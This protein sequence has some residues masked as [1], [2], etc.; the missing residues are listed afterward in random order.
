MLL[1]VDGMSGADRKKA[2]VVAVNPDPERVLAAVSYVIF[3][4]QRKSKKPTQY[5]V[6]KSLFLADR[7]HLNKYG[8]L[9][10]S[11]RY[12]AMKHGPVPTTAYNVLK[13]DGPTLKRYELDHLPWN[14]EAGDG[15]KIYYSDPDISSVDEVLSPSDKVAIED[16]VST[17]LSLSFGQIR[18]LTH[19][20]P[21]YIDAWEDESERKQFPMSLGLLFE[22][23]NFERAR[24]LSD[25]SKL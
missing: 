15:G 10:S 21:A 6:V 3:T 17:V 16:A 2:E 9:V 23:P 18:R 12:V 20:D 5:D 1:V 11:D 8:R 25:M 22:S 7:T 19:D 24:E 14:S 4:A 13:N